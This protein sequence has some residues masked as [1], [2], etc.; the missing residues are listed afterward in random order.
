MC[1]HLFHLFLFLDHDFHCKTKTRS[2]LK[3]YQ[4]ESKKMHVRQDGFKNYIGGSWTR[5]KV[6]RDNIGSGIMRWLKKK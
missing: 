2:S 1:S 5:N 3:V 6:I 4:K